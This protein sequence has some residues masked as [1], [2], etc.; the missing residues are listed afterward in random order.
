MHDN[1]VTQEAWI[2]FAHIT[3]LSWQKDLHKTEV[4]RVLML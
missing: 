4:E 3:G 1:I 2:T